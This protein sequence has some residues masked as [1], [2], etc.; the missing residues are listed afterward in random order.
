MFALSFVVAFGVGVVN[1]GLTVASW[2]LSEV[3][4][5]FGDTI[6]AVNLVAHDKSGDMD[7][8]LR[9]VPDGDEHCITFCTKLLCSACSSATIGASTSLKTCQRAL[10]NGCSAGR[11]WEVLGVNNGT[12][13]GIHK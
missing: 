12:S 9:L 5:W 1:R 3:E 2:L 8:L 6:M 4:D 7:G 13:S 10:Y 11:E